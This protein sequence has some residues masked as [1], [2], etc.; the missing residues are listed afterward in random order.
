MS[1]FQKYELLRLLHEGEAKTFKALERA[2]GRNVLFHM[3]PGDQQNK[4]GSLL[5]RAQK[6][7]GSAGLI[8]VGEFASSPYVVTEY[9]ENLT[10]LSE[11]L[12]SLSPAEAAAPAYS[13]PAKEPDGVPLGIAEEVTS[14]LPERPAGSPA[15][16]LTRPKLEET[17]EF[18]RE[19]DRGLGSMLPAP[20]RKAPEPPPAVEAGE[21][22]RLFEEPFEK[23][24]SPPPMPPPPRAP[25]PFDSPAA[26][27]GEF[28]RLFDEQF[29]KRPSPAPMPPPP[30]APD[31]FDK[32][33][34]SG[35]EFTSM[36]ENA[37]EQRQQREAPQ[38]P[39]G[40]SDFTKF[41]GSGMRSE[42]I[43]IE[44][45]QARQA[46]NPEPFKQPFRQP[47]EFTKRFGPAPGESE[48]AFP[49]DRDSG[50]DWLSTSTDLFGAKAK[51]RKPVPPDADLPSPEQRPPGE[52][53]RVVRLPDAEEQE[54]ANA[55]LNQPPAPP[56]RKRRDL[57]PLIV[58]AV[59][60]VATVV[61][62]LL[63]LLR[64]N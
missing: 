5:E 32:P 54:A 3:L 48:E 14:R 41:F 10:K 24:S 44:E 36:F 30:R 45:E 15:E 62:V 42:P 33:A 51:P 26:E 47:S 1:F 57:A 22:T 28:T 12:A 4:P 11:W 60:L 35:D 29:G 2:T 63:L 34:A 59:L 23:R 64:G 8:E 18:T 50:P 25:D 56:I 39:D 49:A 9:S 16:E 43:N 20:E 53:T 40:P 27:A 17:G 13:P 19:F 7:R 38:A 55:D 6:L 31:P 52:Y 58:A 46:L 61:I 21:F 37:F